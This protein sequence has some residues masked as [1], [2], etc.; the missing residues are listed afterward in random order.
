MQ[1]DALEAGP[2]PCKHDMV[3]DLVT[4]VDFG[5]YSAELY[6]ITSVHCPAHSFDIHMVVQIYCITKSSLHIVFAPAKGVCHVQ[7]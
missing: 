4:P 3:T 2:S 1:A 5:S 7:G 6:I